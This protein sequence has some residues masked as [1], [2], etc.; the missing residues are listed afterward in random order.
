MDEKRRLDP[1][2]CSVARS[3]AV[4][5]ERWS[6]LIVRE[7]VDGA[8]RFGEFRSRLGIAS[9]LLSARLDS[10]VAA[11]VLDRVPYQEPGDRQRFEYRLTPKGTDLRPTLLAL[12]EWGDK[13]LADEEGPGIVV[14]HTATDEDEPCDEPV[15]I[16]L[17]CAAGHTHLRS[18]EVYRAPGPGA[19]FLP[20]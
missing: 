3:L 7:A 10:L 6:L 16:V 15:S 20:A 14:R 13:Y 12:L 9:N 1:A 18:G 2:N 5:G 11:G 19:R 8:R 17:E 4:V